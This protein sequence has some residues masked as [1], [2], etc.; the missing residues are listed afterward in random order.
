M[1]RKLAFLI[2]FAIAAMFPTLGACYEREIN[3]QKAAQ[4]ATN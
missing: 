2:L 1:K 4:E 3:A